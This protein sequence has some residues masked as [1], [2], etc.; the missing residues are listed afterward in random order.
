MVDSDM[1]EELD[2]QAFVPRR[3]QEK[4]LFMKGEK[5]HL[6]VPEYICGRSCSRILILCV[7][8]HSPYTAYTQ[9]AWVLV[10][11]YIEAIVRPVFRQE[12]ILASRQ[13]TAILDNAN[14]SASA[15][16]CLRNI[17]IL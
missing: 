2:P 4:L 6:S 9:V 12:P 17:G 11:V 14:T 7:P 1:T 10:P 5:A 8:K 3:E 16:D 15:Y 13:Q